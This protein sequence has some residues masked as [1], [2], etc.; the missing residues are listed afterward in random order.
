MIKKDVVFEFKS[1]VVY[2]DNENKSSESLSE[3]DAIFESADAKMSAQNSPFVAKPKRRKRR[4]LLKFALGFFVILV[5]IIFAACKIFSYYM[6]T[7]FPEIKDSVLES[8]ELQI[9]ALNEI[10]NNT[11]TVEQYYQKQLLLLFTAD[12]L[13]KALNGISDL[14]GLEELLEFS[15]GVIDAENIISDD[16]IDEYNKILEEYEKASEEGRLDD[17]ASDYI[18]NLN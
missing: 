8:V 7:A 5:L 10:D 12:D 11:L 9:E 2:N 6:E 14:N 4:R 18:E 17:S 15:D 16:K 13:E 1:D 3:I